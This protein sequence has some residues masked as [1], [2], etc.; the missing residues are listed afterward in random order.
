LFEQAL[1]Q[2]KERAAEAAYQLGQLANSRIDYVT[3]AKYFAE[4]V[5]LQ[6]ENPQYLNAA[7]HM[8]YTLGRY[9]DGEP[10]LKRALA[11]WK[12]VLDPEHPYVA[13]SLNNLAWLYQVQ[14]LYAKAEPLYQQVLTIA[15]KALGP[16]HL[17]WQPQLRT[18]PHYW[19]Q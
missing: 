18:T 15:K 12:E 1:N 14:G 9:G 5:K 19:Q 10:L 17:T 2:D 6:P 16:E 11:I 8:A 3:A 4:A 7:G 13:T